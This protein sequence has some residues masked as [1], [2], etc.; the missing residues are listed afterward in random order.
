MLHCPQRPPG[1]RAASRALAHLAWHARQDV[2]PRH[3]RTCQCHSRGCR[4]HARHRGCSGPVLLVLT[5]E[6]G[7]RLWRLADVCAACAA[8][9]AHPAVVPDTALT[10]TRPAEPGKRAQ[11]RRRR[12]RRCG[13]S[14]QV[15]VREMLSYLAAALPARTSPPA[16]LLA[17]QCALRPT[18]PG[19]VNI[20][21]WLLRGMR[22][23]RGTA[24]LSELQGARWLYSSAPPGPGG[25]TA[26]LLDVAVRMQAP[27]AR[28]R[29]R[30]AG[31]VL[32][33]CRRRELRELDAL[34]RLLAL[35][36]AAHVPP[37]WPGALA[38]VEQEVLARMCGLQ[39]QGLAPVLNVLVHARFLHSWVHGPAP[40]DLHWELAVQ[41]EPDS[42]GS[43]LPA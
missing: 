1:R 13:P 14:E 39:A 2:L 37:D 21:T 23:G 7:G 3:L 27:I 24:A 31:W 40:E 25:F 5:R 8:A 11:Q 29:P 10:P 18:G 38:S 43:G 15:R 28:D 20:P 9:T 30:A 4:W 42:D 34:S 19:E 26:Q 33:T 32:R 41:C 12:V 36:L 22:L 35:T 16:R 6:D 17:L